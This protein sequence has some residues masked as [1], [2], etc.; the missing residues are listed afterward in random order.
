M[1]SQHSFSLLK[2]RFGL[3]LF[4]SVLLHQ[5]TQLAVGDTGLVG[6]IVDG[7]ECNVGTIALDKHGVGDNPRTT[8]LALGF[9]GDGKAHLAEM[10][11]QW[12]A[13]ER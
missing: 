3:W 10:L 2:Y 13:H 9:R 4:E 12:F 6:L 8:A 11:A 7:D 1:L 5:F